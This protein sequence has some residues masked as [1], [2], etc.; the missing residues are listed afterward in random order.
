MPV[1][2]GSKYRLVL[3][4]VNCYANT[5]VYHGEGVVGDDG[6]ELEIFVR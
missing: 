1:I 4:A 3:V 5:E 2:D 6:N